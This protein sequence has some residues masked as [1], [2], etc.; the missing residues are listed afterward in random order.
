MRKAI[1]LLTLIAIAGC[2]GFAPEYEER[3]RHSTWDPRGVELL[4]SNRYPGKI[5]CGEYA[6][7]ER[8]RMVRRTRPYVIGTDF[9]LPTP[10]K[11]QVFVFCTR[12]S[13]SA[14]FE[15]YGIGG[16]DIDWNQLRKVS[17]DLMLLS[18]AIDNYYTKNNTLPK[19]L[20]TL[21]SADVGVMEANVTDPWGIPYR[22]EGGLAG[23]TMPNPKLSTYGADGSSGGSGANAD[24]TRAEILLVRH[25]LEVRGD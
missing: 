21:L 19:S 24:V 6:S 14:L 16:P 10:T 9:V 18:E 1:L 25:V 8:N 15:R 2:A 3:L 22:Y 12:D 4:S 5:L 7:W 20:T 23:R 17:D 11:D 13:Q